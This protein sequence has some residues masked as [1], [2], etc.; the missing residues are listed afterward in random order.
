MFNFHLDYY[1]NGRGHHL[2][3][4]GFTFLASII[5][6]LLAVI[7]AISFVIGGIILASSQDYAGEPSGAGVATFL[8]FAL[9]GFLLYF[10]IYIFVLIPMSFGLMKY[11]KDT[12]MSLSPKFSD[13]ALFFK[14]GSFV[15]TLKLTAVLFLLSVAIYVVVYIITFIVQFIFMFFFGFSFAIW[16]PT[17]E[18]YGALSISI[19]VALL[20]MILIMLAI[21][22]PIYY[23]VI[24]MF[25]IV[26]VHIDQQTLPTFTKLSV[27]WNITAKGPNSAWKLL[28][29]NLLYIIAAYII[30]SIVTILVFIIF[31]FLPTAAIIIFSILGYILLLIILIAISYFVY[32]SIVNFY[33]KN[34]ESLYPKNITQTDDV[35]L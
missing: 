9:L 12:D 15:K 26:F 5:F 11:Y 27:A 23:L 19:I 20:L 6:V 1:K 30:L 34:K 18:N 22:I 31:S 4:V 10:V 21:L 16:E 25:N 28:F 35:H 2:R 29:S 24:Y 32:G 7:P 3:T 13:L 33:H 17:A 14:K 8:L